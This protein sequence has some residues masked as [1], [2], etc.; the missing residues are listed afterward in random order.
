MF[1]PFREDLSISGVMVTYLAIKKMQI[2]NVEQLVYGQVGIQSILNK[3]PEKQRL[4][5]LN[6]GVFMYFDAPNMII[7]LRETLFLKYKGSYNFM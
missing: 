1:T 5:D 2:T 7:P 4:K 6:Q 3:L